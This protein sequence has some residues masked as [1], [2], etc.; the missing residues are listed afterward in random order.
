VNRKCLYQY[1]IFPNIST[2]LLKNHFSHLKIEDIDD[3]LFEQIKARLFFDFNNENVDISP[4][5]YSQPEIEST[6][7]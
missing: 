6:N 5:R 7:H 2:K 3:D 1:L 4:H